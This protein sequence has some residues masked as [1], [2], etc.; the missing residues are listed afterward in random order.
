[1]EKHISLQGFEPVSLL[2]LSSKKKVHL[3]EIKNYISVNYITA[4]NTAL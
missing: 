3:E 2:K 1:V 4:D